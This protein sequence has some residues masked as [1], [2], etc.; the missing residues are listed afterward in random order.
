MSVSVRADLVD[1]TREQ[2]DVALRM[3]RGPWPQAQPWMD[4]A[5]VPVV[6]PGLLRRRRPWPLKTLLELP[7][8]HDL[9]PNTHWM[10]WR[11]EMG[12]GTLD[13]ASG[14]AFHSSNLVLEAAAEGLGVALAR[15]RLAQRELAS[16]ALVQPFGP[17]EIPLPQ[18]YW[19]VLPQGHEA[20]PTVRK[21]AVWLRQQAGAMG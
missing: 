17:Y 19:I 18:A 2:V 16:G 8:L 21:F 5:L 4:D 14:Q 15:K 3:G 13:V 1:L 6:S 7:L 12:P 9:D 10:R 11:D 20:N